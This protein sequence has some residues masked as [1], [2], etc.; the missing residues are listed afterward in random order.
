MHSEHLT[1]IKGFEDFINLKTLN[2]SSNNLSGSINISH[3]LI[4][5]VNLSFNNITSINLSTTALTELILSN[6]N[7][8]SLQFIQNIN[9]LEKL[10]VSDNN[11]SD[12]QNLLLIS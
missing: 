11:I 9:N 5:S 4:Q 1:N 10:D 12:D 7:L 6:N 2:L 8:K 3:S